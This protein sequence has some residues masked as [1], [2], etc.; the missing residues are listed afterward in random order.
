MRNERN[1]MNR[2]K[3]IFSLIVATMILF[4]AA[5]LN[6]TA[7]QTLGR[8]LRGNAWAQ[9]TTNN[10]AANDAF[11]AAR[12][13]IDDAQWA[14]AEEAFAKYLS[15]F[16]KET[17]LDAATYWMAYAEYQMKKF[18]K[19]KET[20]EKLMKVYDKSSWKTDAEMLRIQM[21]DVLAAKLEETALTANV[22]AV[23]SDAA[24]TNINAATAKIDTTLA[25]SLSDSITPQVQDQIQETKDR[26]AAAKARSDAR[27]AE[28]KER[29]AQRIKDMQDRMMDRIEFGIGRGVGY[30]IG[31]P[32]ER[33]ADDDPCEFKIVVL[34]SLMESDTAKGISVAND[35]IRPNSGQAV[36]CKRAALRLLGRHGGKAAIPAILESA[37]ND[38]DLK[39]KVMAISV[40]GTTNDD[41]VIDAL[42][43]FA[44]NSSQNEIAEA[45]LY[46]LAQHTSPRAATVL[47][48]LAV[49][50]KALP[51]RK[52]AIQ[53]IARRPGE[54]AVDALLKIYDGS[55][56]I[57]IKKAAISG[58]G[59]RRSE[60]AGAKLLEI[61]QRSDNLELKKAAISAL[62]RRGGDTY[63]DA[64]M[65]LYDHETN[66]EIQDQ[67]L[68]SMAY[69]SDQK[70]VHK[71]I[72]IA[73]NPQTPIQRRQRIVMMLAGRNKNPEVIAFFERLLKQ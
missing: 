27:T 46:A 54:P 13:L 30:G 14:R 21:P 18:D 44:L 7:A 33:L 42:R 50:N 22:A 53:S 5:S 67:I 57:E 38:A 10:P 1:E 32:G 40:L 16:P 11:A 25:Q 28:A 73:E 29:T 3:N 64:L 31:G 6:Q 9:Q 36:S 70:V 69:S 59:Q 39:V 60:R 68:N 17:N 63:V 41:S 20:I 62:G 58:L 55:Q 24:L 12:D 15:Q 23:S 61:A 51:L 19:C 45:A 4:A 49:S 66:V 47:A 56:E 65:N 52:Q 48:D 8:P 2:I 37:K 72:T 43:D 34:Q 35:W 26:L 71:L